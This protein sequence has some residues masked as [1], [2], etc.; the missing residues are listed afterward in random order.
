MLVIRPRPNG[1]F[2]MFQ[3]QTLPLVFSLLLSVSK[4]AGLMIKPNIFHD[5]DVFLLLQ[6]SRK[7]WTQ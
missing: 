5:H 1:H 3:F 7:A 2:E 6:R 4:F